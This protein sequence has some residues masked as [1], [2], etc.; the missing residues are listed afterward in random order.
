MGEESGVLCA[1]GGHE[2]AWAHAPAVVM[3]ALERRT[4]RIRVACGQDTDVALH[5]L[6]GVP[7][8]LRDELTVYL[9]TPQIVGEHP[10]QIA[11]AWLPQRCLP[12]AALENAE[13]EVSLRTLVGLECA[14]MLEMLFVKVK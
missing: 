1:I 8:G 9:E 5:L 7:A 6:D 14:V 2:D 11:L 10:H 4:R 12:G 13:G 3:A